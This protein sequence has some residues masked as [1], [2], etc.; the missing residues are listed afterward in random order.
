MLEV[1]FAIIA[2]LTVYVIGANTT[3]RKLTMSTLESGI[4]AAITS[5]VHLG[6]AFPAD[7]VTCI[8][9]WTVIVTLAKL[10]TSRWILSSNWTSPDWDANEKHLLEDKLI[11]RVLNQEWWQSTHCGRRGFPSRWILSLNWTLPNWDAHE[12]HLLEDELIERVLNKE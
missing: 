1:S 9:T 5:I 11:E 12:N 7:I 4:L 8:G 2:W 3:A 10:P 6:G